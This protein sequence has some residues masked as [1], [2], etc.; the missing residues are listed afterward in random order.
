MV[1][2][3]LID[4]VT[5][6]LAHY[7]AAFNSNSGAQ[8]ATC[9]AAPCLILRADGSLHGLSSSPEIAKFF[10]TRVE[11]LHSEG[12]RDWRYT[13]LEVVPIDRRCVLAVMDWEP[14][15][16]DGTA[17]GKWR[18]TYQLLRTESGLRFM[19]ST[20]HAQ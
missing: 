19:V 1:H 8:I 3:Q 4:E 14:L 18:Q 13:N 2:S 6:C 17:L 20:V 7:I 12:C 15:R 16:A 11:Q 9:Y 5:N 10:Q